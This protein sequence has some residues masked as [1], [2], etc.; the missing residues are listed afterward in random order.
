MAIV[1]R[2]IAAQERTFLPST[3]SVPTATSLVA[4]DGRPRCCY[5]RQI[6]PS[7]SCK[8]I[9]DVAHRKSILK[10]TGR[11]F[12]CLKRHHMSKDCCSPVLCAKCNGH[13]HT[14]VCTGSVTTQSANTQVVPANPSFQAGRNSTPQFL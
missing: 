9:T 13:H 10:K 2:E 14:S 4:G 6:H 5:C 8:M 3:R 12:V 1:G 11:C 7:V